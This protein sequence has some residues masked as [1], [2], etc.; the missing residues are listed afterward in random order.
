[1][2]FNDTRL[3]RHNT[4]VTPS[5][6]CA[7]LI[8][9]LVV[10]S[11]SGVL[12]FSDPSPENHFPTCLVT[13]SIQVSQFSFL[14][15]CSNFVIKSPSSTEDALDSVA[16]FSWLPTVFCATCSL[17]WLVFVVIVETVPKICFFWSLLPLHLFLSVSS[18]FL[19]ISSPLPISENSLS[20]FVVPPHSA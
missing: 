7:A 1:M 2:D 18:V 13:C 16:P 14:S 8:T 11:Q 5:H 4:L 10:L 9:L 3:T 20:L 6:C 19:L 15:I 17:T 12:C